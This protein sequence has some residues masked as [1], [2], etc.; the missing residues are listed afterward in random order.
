MPMLLLLLLFSEV[1][2]LIKLGQAIGGAFVLVELVAT[3]ALGYALLR[4]AGRSFLRTDEL[5]DLM[6]NPGRYFR[7]SGWA[8]ILAGLLLIVPGLLSDLLG[9][10]LAGRFLW[11]RITGRSSRRPETTR[12][13]E[14]IDVE[15]R[16]HEDES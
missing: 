15:Y 9:L 2:V 10:F 6:A 7:R 13:P 14:T 16:V 5:V 3:A 8:L 12:D 11:A 4:A 1:A